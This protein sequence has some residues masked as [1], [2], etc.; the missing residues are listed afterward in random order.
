MWFDH[1]AR[2]V[3]KRRSRRNIN[4]PRRRRQIGL[5]IPPRRVDQSKEPQSVAIDLRTD[6]ARPADVASETEF[7][8]LQDQMPHGDLLPGDDSGALQ[9]NVGGHDRRG[10]FPGQQKPQPSRADK[11][12]MAPPRLLFA[13][14]SRKN[15]KKSRASPFEELARCLCPLGFVSIFYF[16]SVTTAET[17]VCCWYMQ[18]SPAKGPAMGPSSPQA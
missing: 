18:F 7:R 8:E 14:K 12:P 2:T 16:S 1:V 17:K 3:P 15:K 11:P 13:R 5:A 6:L 10:A 9:G 4:S